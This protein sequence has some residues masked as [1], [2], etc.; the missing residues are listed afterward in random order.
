[1][2][3]FPS[4][5][6]VHTA[7]L[8]FAHTLVNTALYRRVLRTVSRTYKCPNAVSLPQEYGSQWNG[9]HWA[10]VK[11][12]IC[13]IKILFVSTS[14][15]TCVCVLVA[16]AFNSVSFL[17]ANCRCCAVGVPKKLFAPHTGVECHLPFFIECPL[18]SLS[19]LHFVVIMVSD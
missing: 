12:K 8:P 5:R 6:I 11:H 16:M 17:C 15:R 2:Q 7:S 4:Y 13:K 10:D 14:S 9:S 19:K 18:D 1:M 3:N